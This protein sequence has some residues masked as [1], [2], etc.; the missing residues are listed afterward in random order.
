MR[1]ENPFS[2]VERLKRVKNIPTEPVDERVPPGQ[3]LTDR[4]PVLTYGPTPRYENLTNWTLRVFGLVEEE[5]V[6]TWEDLMRMPRKTETVDI[7]C[8]TRWSKLDTTWTGVPWREFI[9]H[10]RIKPEATHVMVHCEY[11]YTTN[12]AL[13]VLDD[14]D[15][16]LAFEY[17]GK[18]LEPEHGYP[19][20]LLVPKKY[21]WKSAKW[22][23]GFEFMDRDRPGFW[24]RAGYHMEGDPWKEERF[25]W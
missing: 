22:V 6:F 8:V 21:F 12:V 25:G 18:P 19:L 2:R 1:I 7:H 9:K 14:D 16:L 10:F 11:G 4:F 5:K 23:R 13:D 17:E 24:E 20:R 15:T 3:F